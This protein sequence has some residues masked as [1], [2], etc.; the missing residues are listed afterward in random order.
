[1]PP[2][3]QIDEERRMAYAGIYLLEHMRNDR[4]TFPLLLEADE[5]DL[6]PVLEW[7]LT[8]GC[9]D[10]EDDARYGIADKG[11]A[12]LDRFDKRYREYLACY[13][14]FCA[15]DLEAGAFAFAHVDD[16]DNREQWEAFLAEDRWEDLR[17]AVAEHLGA[18]PVEIVFMSFINERRFGRD[19]TGWQFDLL[20][21][22]VWDTILE[23]CDRALH[24]EDLGFDDGGVE[25]SG[26]EVVADVY[27]QG[28]EL[29]EEIAGRALPGAGGAGDSAVDTAVRDFRY[30]DPDRASD[31]TRDGW[32]IT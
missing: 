31:L 10:I 26:G 2:T 32:E 15:V 30:R 29:M 3:F 4:K 18:D 27:R 16:F 12:A 24:V 17:I 9:V 21:G 14:V 5:A 13:D 20:L 6:E 28:I 7:L 23:I 8:H 22:S 1:M 25:I 19:A 11:R